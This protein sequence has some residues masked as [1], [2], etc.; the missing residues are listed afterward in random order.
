MAPR[1]AKAKTASAGRETRSTTLN[2][3]SSS[4]GGISKRRGQG[5]VDNDGD[6]DMGAGATRTQHGGD[7]NARGRGDGKTGRG[8]SKTA[9]TI[10]KHLTSGDADRIS[11]RVKNPEAAKQARS[12]A[13]AAPVVYLRVHGHKASKA[14]SSKD[15]GL[16]QLLAFLERKATERVRSKSRNVIIRKVC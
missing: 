10:L 4:R 5:R 2:S 11:S 15:G 14:S 8:A 1:G 6:L 9:Q 13:N 16:S 3:K 7:G 12:K